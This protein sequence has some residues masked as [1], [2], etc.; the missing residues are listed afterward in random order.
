MCFQFQLGLNTAVTYKEGDRQK[1]V[2][3]HANGKDDTRWMRSIGGL[4]TQVS[5]FICEFNF[6]HLESKNATKIK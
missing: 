2:F 4:T 5:S 6:D 1:D 3:S